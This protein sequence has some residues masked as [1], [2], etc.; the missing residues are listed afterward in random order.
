MKTLRQT[1]LQFHIVIKTDNDE[2]AMTVLATFWL[3]WKFVGLIGSNIKRF[4]TNQTS[5]LVHAW[6]IFQIIIVSIAFGFFGLNITFA[7]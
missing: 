2:V 7:K 1:V 3:L 4:F 6:F 5:D